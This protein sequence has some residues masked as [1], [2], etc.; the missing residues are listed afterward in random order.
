M[1]IYLGWSDKNSAHLC[2]VFGKDERKKFNP[3]ETESLMR[4]VE[5]LRVLQ[6]PH[7]IKFHNFFDENPEKSYM[8]RGGVFSSLQLVADGFPRCTLV[9]ARAGGT[10]RERERVRKLEDD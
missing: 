1:G 10:Q 2:G 7:I 4:E 3:K 8:V 6:H 5:F 9:N